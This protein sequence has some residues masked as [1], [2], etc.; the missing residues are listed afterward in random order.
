MLLLLQQHKPGMLE[1]H[2]EAHLSQHEVGIPRI[3]TIDMD[4]GIS[5]GLAEEGHAV[6]M[7]PRGAHAVPRRH[8]AALR[9][10]REQ[11][12]NVDDQCVA[13]VRCGDPRAG[14]VQH[15]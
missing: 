8:E 10:V 4:E 13:H 11:I 7:G 1:F 3:G 2:P 15:F 5:A 9:Q 12:A 6:A 14:R